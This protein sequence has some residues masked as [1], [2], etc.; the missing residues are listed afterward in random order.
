MFQ[1]QQVGCLSP[2]VS[3]AVDAAGSA[4]TG[5]SESNVEMCPCT[6]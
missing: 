3:A 5:L 6:V 4:V 2:E 1:Y